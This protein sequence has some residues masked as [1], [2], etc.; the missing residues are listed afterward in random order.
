MKNRLEKMYKEIPLI[1]N[2][3]GIGMAW[4]IELVRDRK[5]KKPATEET[6]KVLS[7]CLKNGL[8]IIKAGL[9]NNVIRI[10]PP[11]VITEDQLNEGFDILEKVLVSVSN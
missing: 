11:L 8:I 3:R 2:L 6:K 4:G 5:T 7:E 10:I 9:Y 1:G